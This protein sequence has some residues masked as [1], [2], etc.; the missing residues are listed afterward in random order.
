MLKYLLFIKKI[1]IKINIAN[2]CLKKKKLGDLIE[3][4]QK[5]DPNNLN[6]HMKNVADLLKLY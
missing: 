6:E 3:V 4:I 1:K 5:T 2:C